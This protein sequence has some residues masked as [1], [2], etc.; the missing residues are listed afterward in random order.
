[1]ALD[2]ACAGD[3]L[4]V[5]RL[6]RLGRV[7]ARPDPARQ[8][9]RRDGHRP[10]ERAGEDRYQFQ[11]RPAGVPHVRRPRQVRRNLVRERTQAGLN[12]RRGRKGGRT[13]VL[14][15]AKRQLV[16]KLYAEKQHTIGE[17]LPDDGDLQ[18]DALQLH[19]YMN[20]AGRPPQP[21]DRVSGQGRLG[22]RPSGRPLDCHEA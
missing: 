7:A 11:R 3:V 22:A 8:E 5:W 14:D 21:L 18:T 9:A 17:D 16:A 2:V 1:M 4:T 13:K 10:D 19:T 6:D 12:A 15:P 20:R